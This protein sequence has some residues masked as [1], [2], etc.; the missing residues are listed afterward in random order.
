MAR[1]F[2]RPTIVYFQLTRNAVMEGDVDVHGSNTYLA[3]L[4]VVKADS[5]CLKKNTDQHQIQAATGVQMS[6]IALMD[7]D[8]KGVCD[9]LSIPQV[10]SS[11][12]IV[13]VEILGEKVCSDI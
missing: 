2:L 12:E 13:F 5:K 6:R 8:V 4:E 9:F 11:F 7:D 3:L 10:C 1:V